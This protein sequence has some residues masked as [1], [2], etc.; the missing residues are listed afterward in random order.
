MPGYLKTTPRALTDPSP[1]GGSASS[2]SSVSPLFALRNSSTVMGGAGSSGLTS[3]W[4]W[5]TWGSS[6]PN[7][8]SPLATA[9]WGS[10]SR[11]TVP[12]SRAITLSAIGRTFSTLCSA[13]M[14]VM[15][16]SFS[17]PSSSNTSLVPTA[18][19]MDVG[20]SSMRTLGLKASMAAMASLCF[21]PPLSRKVG[22]PLLRQ[23]PTSLRD[24]WTLAL[25]SSGGTALFSKPKATS[26]STTSA[27]IWLSGT[28]YT[29][30]TSTA[31]LYTGAVLGSFPNTEILPRTSALIMLGITP[32]I[33]LINVDLPEPVLPTNNTNSP[34]S[35]SRV[36]SLRASR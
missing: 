34:S 4:S 27:N 33:A 14:T 12:L 11:A 32:F 24:S 30:P 9:L 10:S 13:T 15:P 17:S 22:W 29:V 3:L 6:T 16:R 23:R 5:A 18:S 26:S 25:I 28:W 8:W 20:S 31:V 21:S 35:I 1:A 2:T 36:T 19:S 7:F